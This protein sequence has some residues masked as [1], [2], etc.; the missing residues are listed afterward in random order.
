MLMMMMVVVITL[1]ADLQAEVKTPSREN[2]D[3]PVV[4]VVES[5]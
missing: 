5:E 1:L 4:I 2:D 3:H